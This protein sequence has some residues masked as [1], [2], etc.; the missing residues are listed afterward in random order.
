MTKFEIVTLNKAKDFIDSLDK[1]RKA[2]VDRFYYLFEDYGFNL[3]DKYLR[4][5]K[6][7][8]WELRPG[9][10]RLFLTIKGTTGFVVHAILK[11]SQ[12]IPKKDLD[13]AI[14]RAKEEV[15]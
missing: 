6:G 4:K 12:K 8:I 9:N 7:D 15:R 11:K 1:I 13:L 10:V 3:P 5:V 2:R 14:K